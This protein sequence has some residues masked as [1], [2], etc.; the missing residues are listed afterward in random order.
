[1]VKAWAL[2]ETYFQGE[3]FDIP[4]REQALIITNEGY[5][6]NRI[7]IFRGEKVKFFITSL[8]DEPACFVM[9]DKSVYATATKGKMSETETMFDKVGTY[10]YQCPHSKYQGRIVVL[11]R[12][13]EAQERKR[14]GLA[15]ENVKVWK[16]KD[17][18]LE[19][20]DME[21]KE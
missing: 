11:E 14:R 5:Y 1:M 17:E 19:F 20:Q 9:P 2:E 12:P 21:F 16:P 4:M 15:S 8:T 10:V 3:K 13:S 18:P 6:P 7:S